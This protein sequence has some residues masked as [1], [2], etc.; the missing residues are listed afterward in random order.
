MNPSRI[1]AI[2]ARW[3]LIRQAHAGDLDSVAARQALVLRYA[4]AI[5][6]YLGK[7]VSQADDADELAQDAMMRLMRG[8]FA[9]ADPTRGRFRDFLK[10]ALRNMAKNYWANLKRRR[11]GTADLDQIAG[12]DENDLAWQQAWQATVLDQ[13]MAAVAHADTQSTTR[14]AAVLKLRTDFPDASSEELAAKL[15]ERTGHPVRAEAARQLLRRARLRLAECLVEEI[16]RGLE[17][18]TPAR[19]LEELADLRLLELVRD[20]LPDD[21][22]ATGCL[23]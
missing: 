19:V 1:D 18:N 21:F 9:G 17:D 22:A 6:K 2:D 13:A 4:G 11:L 7:I 23:K 3:S 10:T 14:H 8:D 15:S 12:A 16:H 5:R 20:F